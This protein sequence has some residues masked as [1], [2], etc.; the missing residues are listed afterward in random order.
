MDTSE[1]SAYKPSIVSLQ[2][3]QEQNTMDMKEKTK[4]YKE[5]TQGIKNTP[6]MDTLE[7]QYTDMT[8]FDNQ[9]KTNLILWAVIS[10]TI[11]AILLIRK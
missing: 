1:M 5:V 9:N 11:L 8:V 2:Q 10:T 3:K 4:T 7:Q 6:D